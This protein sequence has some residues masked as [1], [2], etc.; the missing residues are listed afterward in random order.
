VADI[1]DLRPYDGPLGQEETRLAARRIAVVRDPAGRTSLVRANSV[2][3]EFDGDEVER[4]AEVLAR[5]GLEMLG[6]SA[7]PA[8]GG[9]VGARELAST[10]RSDGRSIDDARRLADTLRRADLRVRANHVFLADGVAASFGVVGKDLAGGTPGIGPPVELDS[11][12]RP[13]L[14]PRHLAEPLRLS[15]H[16]P[17]HVL[18][19]D[20]GLRTR[21]G[22]PEHPDLTNCF[23]H[24]N[25][26]NRA[27][28]GRFDD[29]DEPDD[30]HR[31]QLDTQAGHGTFI[32]GIVCQRCPDAVV[33]HAGVLT[34]YGDGDHASIVNA[35][36]RALARPGDGYDVVVMA[37][38]TYAVDD[39]VAA[40]QQ[41]IDRLLT[42]SVVVASA[43]N[44]ATAR[45]YYPAA[46]PGVIAVGALGADGRAA[47][48]NF[49]PWV[50][51]CAP[52]VDVVSTFFCDFD[53]RRAGRAAVD[54]Y[55]GWAA[56]SG[57]S[58]AAPQVAG[59]IAQ[60]QYLG[61]GTA[62][63]A[64]QRLT[65]SPRFRLPNLGQVFTT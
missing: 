47:F 26:L 4:V 62:H 23:I 60:E 58:F 11:T 56:W 51:A 48:S 1:E 32:S 5:P 54:R 27:E 20:T 17:P 16:R 64:W 61:G 42:T 36:D 63:D 24:A 40:M 22:H 30:D 34:S 52:G 57:T 29:E 43:G 14:A 31:G 19:L 9:L 12:A 35:I 49:G 37:L 65:T 41:V 2:M 8:G 7:P 6:R 46:L 10:S 55:R 13:A 21:D 44:D 33:H 53:D 59:A 28:T 38:G 18:V 39:D 3:V 15:G 25:W 45:P 50:D